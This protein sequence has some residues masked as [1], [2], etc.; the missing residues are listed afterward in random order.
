M[1]DEPKNQLERITNYNVIRNLNAVFLG[2]CDFFS[3]SY[4]R[5][6]FTSTVDTLFG[7]SLLLIFQK[8]LDI[9]LP[10]KQLFVSFPHIS[11]AYLLLN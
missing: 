7:N 6:I 9:L 1:T 11:S 8:H 2:F 3:K 10:K 5:L 4:L